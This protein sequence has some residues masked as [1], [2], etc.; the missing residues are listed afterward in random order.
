MKKNLADPRRLLRSDSI[1]QL[2]ELPRIEASTKMNMHDA[3]LRIGWE[4]NWVFFKSSSKRAITL[5]D[6]GKKSKLGADSNEELLYSILIWNSFNKHIA[7]PIAVA[8]FNGDAV[9]YFMEYVKGTL[10]A[11]I[12]PVNRRPAVLNLAGVISN[13]HS[14]GLVHGDLHEYNVICKEDNT[15]KLIDPIGWAVL[16]HA[17]WVEA[18]DLLSIGKNAGIRDEISKFYFNR[19]SEGRI[20]AKSMEHKYNECL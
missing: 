19:F 2:L 3:L 5:W 18:L 9:G 13:L 1:T 8:T 17:I 11:D 7:E 6:N 15:I 16:E 20:Y 10:L 4:P 14:H 12:A